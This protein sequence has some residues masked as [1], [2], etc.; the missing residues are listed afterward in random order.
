[1]YSLHDLLKGKNLDIVAAALL[2]SGK[3]KVDSVE[4]FRGSPV[5]VVSLL[6]KYKTLENE[7]VSKITEFLADNG[8]MTL[9]DLFE[10]IKQR[11]QK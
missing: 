1:M 7:K 4:L 2:L 3:L 10:A 9:D 11:T 6:G 8:D 5:I